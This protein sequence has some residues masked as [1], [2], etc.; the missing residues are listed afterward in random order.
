[1]L[2]V[3]TLCALSACFASVGGIRTARSEAPTPRPLGDV[4]VVRAVFSTPDKRIDFARAKLAFDKLADPTIDADASLKEID[5]MEQ[6]IRTM[7]GPS[8]PSRLRLITLRKFIYEPGLWNDNRPF[9]YDLT[10]PFGRKP[11]NRLL[12]TYLRTRRG[13]CVSM[14]ILFVALAQRLGLPA[15]L[16][17]APGHIFVKYFDD[18]TGKT[19]N[20]ETTS[21]AHVA[22]DVWIRQNM[23]MTDQAIANGVYMK[24]LSKK[25]ALVVMAD[26][27]MEHEIHE[28][29]YQEAWDLADA[30]RPYYPNNLQAILTPA[31]A[32]ALMIETEY[33]GKYPT[34]QDI[35]PELIDRFYFLEKVIPA[36]F[37]HAEA[38]GWRMTDGQPQ[39]ASVAR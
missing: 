17:T 11:E 36:S 21:G 33:R 2:R 5:Y 25:E 22:R 19:V 32:A 3:I 30:I 35:P 13:N 14:P 23:P 31:T 18:V 4:Q 16:S 12:S 15:T 28:K 34:R 9:Q 27:V 29:H 8:A 26:V 10:D 37:K 38:L 24:A 20:L 39:Q 1:M 7:A 6:T